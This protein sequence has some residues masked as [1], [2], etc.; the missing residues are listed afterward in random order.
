MQLEEIKTSKSWRAAMLLR[1]IRLK[2]VPKESW[3]EYALR[4]LYN[5]PAPLLKVA[6]RL[7]HEMVRIISFQESSVYYYRKWRTRNEPDKKTLTQQSDLAGQFPVQ[8]LISIIIPVYHPPL[9]VLKQTID[10][11]FQQ[12]YPNWELCV[13]DAS[14]GNSSIKDLLA[15]YA[16][17]DSR[18]RIVDLSTNLGIAGNANAGIQI[19]SGDYVAFL[20]HDDMLHP[21]AL[22]EIVSQINHDPEIDVLYSDEDK[23][24]GSGRRFAPFF[25]PSYN[26]DLLQSVNYI[27]HFL[28]VRRSLGDHVEWLRSGFEGAQDFDF[29]L[30]LAEKTKRIVRIPRI[31]Y[32]WRAIPGSTATNAA[33]KP[34]AVTSGKHALDEH[35]QRAGLDATVADGMFPTFYRINY[36][37]KEQPLVS[38][39]IPNHNHA[40]DLSHCV[41]SILNKSSYPRYEI[42]IAENNSAPEVRALYQD[43]QKSDGRIRMIEWK[44]AFN[45]S[46]VN[47]WAVT[48]TN[49]EVL[50]FLNNDIEV[51]NA[52]WLEQMLMHALRPE[53]GMVGAKLC[54]PDDTIQHAGIVLGIG[55]VA[56]HGH[57]RFPRTSP[58][59]FGQLVQVRN[60]LAVTAA[61]AM[62]RR[63]VFEEVKGFDPNYILAFG[64]VDLC[65]KIY[66][67]GY[68]NLWTPFAELYHHESK[69]RGYEDTSGKQ[70][71]FTREVRYFK[72][73]WAHQLK[74]GDPYYNPNLSLEFDDYR[75]DF[76]EHGD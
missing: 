26:P 22:F 23:I 43:L 47:N 70:L 38:I 57:K 49:G 4:N 18:I 67:S 13:A 73:K 33:Y 40:E 35:L 15:Q 44:E 24:D 29:V 68:R 53:I 66:E 19:S 32:H 74:E 16:E 52:D 2:L 59:Y 8:P 56:G 69:T 60:V 62:V 51:I 54:Y 63:S 41:N 3:V 36:K 46:A 12:T 72:Q 9:D 45:Y 14:T 21:S 31:L 20:D 42:L 71:R 50:L 75:I 25:K 37:L 17:S 58:G 11:V 64:D 6:K 30:R 76:Q 28:V 61:C 39:I 34:Q 65:L 10:S 1:R 48:R 5:S 55:G 7:G 27:C